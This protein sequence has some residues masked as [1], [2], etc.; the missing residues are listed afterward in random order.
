MIKR[1]I[2]LLMF[3]GLVSLM[4]CKGQKEEKNDITNEKLNIVFIAIDDMNTWVGAMGGAAKT[5]AIDKLAS[6]GKLFTNAHCVVPACN[7]S[8]VAIMTGLRPE[9]TGQYTNPGNFRDKPGNADRI[10]LPKYLQQFGYESIGI[11]KIFHKEAGKGDE[12]H[13]QSDPESWS[14]QYPNGIG[15]KGHQLYLDENNQALWLE[16]AMYEEGMNIKKP[17]YLSKFGVWGITPEKKEETADWQ[18]A[19]FAAEYMSKKHEKPFFLSVGFMRP[20]SPQIAP[21]EFFDMYPLESVKIPELP[22]DD[23]DDVPQ[24]AKRNFSSN[25]VDHVKAKQQLQKA[26]QG[27]LASISFVDACISEVL[28]GIENGPNKD[29]TIVVLWSD[30]GW[31]L[32]HKNRWE[33]FSLWNQATNAPLVIKYPNMK[34]EG[35]ATNQAV[36]LLDLFPTVLDLSGIEKPEFLEGESLKSLLENPNYTRKEPALVTYEKG[37]ISAHKNEWNLIQYKNGAEEMYNLKSDPH[38]FNNIINE[39]GNESIKNELRAAIANLKEK[40]I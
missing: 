38:E 27:Y 21:K 24:I 33:K 1:R 16:G 29:N 9:T 25:F 11:G 7:P 32:A 8:R 31:Q 19:T 12:P 37:N 4:S 2:V 23:T 26:T 6:E 18:N 35:I 34:H 28:K 30:H 10:T 14:Y 22:E 20:H 13:P 3:I 17:N 40:S 36:S 39:E 5:P 15:T